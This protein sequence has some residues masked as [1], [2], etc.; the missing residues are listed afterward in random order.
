MSDAEPTPQPRL[1]F[2]HV[3]AI[4]A[5]AMFSSG[6]FLLPGIAAA[7][8]GPSLPLAYLL[9]G[10][11]VLPTMLSVTELSVAMPFAGGPYHFY[12][13]SLGP[14]AAT[15]GGIGLWVALVLKSSFAL[16]G[17]DAYL[18]LVVDLPAGVV[19][20]TLAVA[21]TLLN[22]AGAR[23]SAAIQVGLV[24]VL[25]VVLTAFVVAG[26][27]T[28]VGLDDERLAERFSPLFSGGVLGLLA[29]T[30]IVFV[31]FA[32]LPQVA[33]VAGDIRDPART[34]PRGILAALA[35]A[36]TV[37][38][39]GTAILVWTLPADELRDDTTPIATSAETFGIPFAV[40]LIV[41]AALAAFASTG[42]AGI[43]S[44]S[45]YPLALARDGIVWSRFARMNDA[46]VPV[47]AVILSGATIAVVVTV[48]DV[49]GIAKLASAFVLI[50]FG[51]MNASVIIL[52]RARVPGYQPSFRVPWSPWVPGFGVLTSVVL[53]IDLG[54][55]A[56]G[57]AL[58]L[59]VGGTAWHR[60]ARRGEQDTSGALMALGRRRGRRLSADDIA[61]LQE[62]GPRA[63]DAAPETLERAVAR[64]LPRGADH[65][66]LRHEA[67][68][69]LSEVEAISVDEASAWL[70][71]SRH[72]LVELDDGSEVHLLDLDAPAEPVVVIVWSPDDNSDT[73]DHRHAGT[74]DQDTERRGLTVAVVAAFTADLDRAA[75]LTALLTVQLDNPKLRDQWPTDPRCVGELLATDAGRR[76]GA[77]QPPPAHGRR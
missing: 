71:D 2:V 72:A 6:F 36:T 3:F 19:G 21:F 35:V 12:R 23:E 24:A 20:V 34:I 44:A 64:R 70:A 49:E 51:L 32:G 18:T 11:L 25:L 31:A 52:R 74:D 40:P 1:R 54:A 56:V 67:A 60:W 62:A 9:A 15:I 38:V 58:A 37:Y 5:G 77:D 30:G 46:G 22:I 16:E 42:N 50:S 26:G 4:G 66:E 48:F 17:I 39:A 14:T 10:L 13:R 55:L 65:V 69:A 8:T 61:E 76:Q 53:V 73:D 57:A 27:V 75:R 29:A 63:E 7:E 41:I 45:R 43:M 28:S 68:S 33:S 59:V 47:A